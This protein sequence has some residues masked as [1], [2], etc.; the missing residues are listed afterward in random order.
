[1][2]T[3]NQ[4]GEQ[5]EFRYVGGR[6]TPIH[7]SGRWCSGYSSGASQAVAKPFQTIVSY[8]NPNA[9]CPVCGERVYFY[10]SPNGGRVFFNDLGWPWEK[11]GCTDSS[12][13]Q[14]GTVK[15]VKQ[16]GNA[17]FRNRDGEAL[18]LYELWSLT[19]KGN[20]VQ[21]RFSRIGEN[22]SFGASVSIGELRTWDVTVRDLRDAPSFAVRIKDGHRLLEFIS[23]RKKS[24]DRIVV[25][26]PK[27]ST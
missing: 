22:R 6:P 26:K 27:P 16:G 12:R 23:G 1:M 11:H 5:I 8:V 2:P 10:Q 4:C 17:S 18:D 20:V 19:E 15:T 24:I 21:M 9:H 7:V 3:C 25:K 14:T 13:S